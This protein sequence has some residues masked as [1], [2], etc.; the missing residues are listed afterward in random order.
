MKAPSSSSALMKVSTRSLARS[1]ATTP[2][3][4]PF[5]PHISSWPNS[6]MPKV[7][8]YPSSHSLVHQELIEDNIT[9][10]KIYQISSNLLSKFLQNDVILVSV[11]KFLSCLCN[12]ADGRQTLIQQNV[13]VH[14]LGILSSHP[15]TDVA[16]ASATNLLWKL[17]I[18]RMQSSSVMMLCR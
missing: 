14:L 12:S 18:E 15:H 8:F 6:R 11:C 5:V 13:V 3:L 4:R 9:S 2:T 7:C 17:T 10:N 1:S 16:F